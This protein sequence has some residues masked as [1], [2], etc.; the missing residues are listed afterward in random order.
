MPFIPGLKGGGQVGL[1]QCGLHSEFQARQN[2]LVRLYP[3][4]KNK[5][6]KYKAD[7]RGEA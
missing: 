3:A 7:Y 6:L 2:Y 4:Q 1:C 5:S